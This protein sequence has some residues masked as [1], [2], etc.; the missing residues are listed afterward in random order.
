MTPRGRLA[1][2]AVLALASSFVFF[3]PASAAI[4]GAQAGQI[5]LQ[6]LAPK[7]GEVVHELP[8]PVPATAVLT[9]PGP[10]GLEAS[11]TVLESDTLVTPL[12]HQP[13]GRPVW[14][15]WED[16]LPVAMWPHP[17]VLL[18]L[19]ARTGQLVRKVGLAWW[20]LIDG[21]S[22]F[23]RAVSA[24]LRAAQFGAAR[25]SRLVAE[26]TGEASQS[27]VIEV[28]DFSTTDT[29][30]NFAAWD[31]FA[32][33][34]TGAPAIPVDGSKGLTAAVRSA[35]A[36]GA[37]DILL[38][39]NGHQFST[40]NPGQWDGLGAAFDWANHVWSG[41][42]PGPYVSLTSA[43][44]LF[45]TWKQGILT[46]AKVRAELLSA[47]QQLPGLS[48][49]VLVEA[50]GSG[51]W[52][53]ELTGVTDHFMTSVTNGRFSLG[54]KGGHASPFTTAAIGP[55]SSTLRSDPRLTLTAALGQTEQAIATAT[56]ALGK[57]QDAFYPQNP[58]YDEQRELPKATTTTTVA[59]R[60]KTTTTRATTTTRPK[61]ATTTTTRKST[62]TTSGATTTTMSTVSTTTTAPAQLSLTLSVDEEETFSPT[63][64]F[65]GSGLGEVYADAPGY[66]EQ[67]A[68]NDGYTLDPPSYPDGTQVT[69][70]AVPDKGSAFEGWIGLCAAVGDDPTC[71]LTLTG[72]TYIAAAFKVQSY[73]LTV[74]NP[75]LANWV[76]DTTGGPGTSPLDVSCGNSADMCSGEEPAQSLCS[77]RDVGVLCTGPPWG[78]NSQVELV[79]VAYAPNT[80]FGSFDGCDRWS[81]DANDPTIGYCLLNMTSDRT[82]RVNWVTA[83]GNA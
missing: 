45:H 54:P 24:S 80:Q 63:G 19:D 52:A 17:S 21:Q 29:A 15:F 62:S 74:D 49:S 28:G 56:A 10:G 55:L 32:Q 70:L 51:N 2:T 46:A 26:G 47:R 75:D 5:A 4:T 57:K 12:G 18:L 40:Q 11:G 43:P 78:Y 41:S 27:R 65:L 83:T 50:C 68:G 72:Y 33:S 61:K 1:L 39:I 82:V 42:Q 44:G 37:R 9:E 59:T 23:V 58:V 60:N 14:L 8:A 38:Y 3:A 16:L 22:P 64:G 66:P 81:P 77:P 6:I 13:I 73:T 31:K 25:R 34:S 35:Y 71:V 7:D 69:L 30:P 67:E 20:P 48:I 36:N 53:S 76:H 79:A